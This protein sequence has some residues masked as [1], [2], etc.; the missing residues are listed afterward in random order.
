MTPTQRATC[1]LDFLPC[2][3]SAHSILR[4]YHTASTPPG[5]GPAILLSHSSSKGYPKQIN[6]VSTVSHTDTHL[7]RTRQLIAGLIRDSLLRITHPAIITDALSFSGQW[8]VEGD[9]SSGR[10]GS[11]HLSTHIGDQ[12]NLI[13]TGK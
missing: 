11:F 5:P 12:A 9:A 1:A 4:P 13:F 2:P 7:H 6:D 10:N 8:T 3:I